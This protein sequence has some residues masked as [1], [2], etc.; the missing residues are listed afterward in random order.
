MAVLFALLLL[1][2]I[3][4]LIAYAVGLRNDLMKIRRNIDKSFAGIDMLLK[5]RHDELPKLLET[6]RPYFQNQQ[7]V[8][9]SVVEARNAYRQ[10]ASPAQK[11]QADQLVSGAIQNLLAVAAKNPDL[12]TNA[13]FL[14][15]Q[16]RIAQLAEKVAAER[17][18]YNANVNSFNVRISR[19]PHALVARFAKLQ[20]REP[21]QAG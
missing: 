6:C 13:S 20:A 4:G 7:R 9:H 2:V 19:V 15:L 1:L 8:L 14:R 17:D 21:F 5:Q 11:A 3:L 12:K 18:L 16:A 10:A